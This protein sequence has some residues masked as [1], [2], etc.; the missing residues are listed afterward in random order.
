VIA[1]STFAQDN[2]QPPSV[3]VSLVVSNIISASGNPSPRLPR[4]WHLEHTSKPPYYLFQ[5]TATASTKR[6]STS[7]NF[8][9][10]FG[11]LPKFRRVAAGSD[12]RSPSNETR[13]NGRLCACSRALPVGMR[14]SRSERAVCSHWQDHERTL[15]VHNK[16]PDR[17]E[18]PVE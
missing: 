16:R 5:V 3:H 18:P 12:R 14:C 15:Y 10:T 17:V 8:V 6:G 1:T 9:G 7:N 11:A 2:D 13:A 4:C